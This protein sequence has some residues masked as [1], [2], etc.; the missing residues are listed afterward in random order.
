MPAFDPDLTPTRGMGAIAETFRKQMDV[1]RSSHPQVSFTAWGDDCISIVQNHSLAF[2][3]GE[4]SP[5]A[6]MYDRDGWVLL[7]GVGHDS[8]TSL[9]LAEDRA[10]YRKKE[11]IRCSSP[12]L[13]EGHRRWKQYEDWNYDDSD[14]RELGHDFLKDNQDTVAVGSI[15]YAKCQLFSQRLCVDYAADWFEHKRR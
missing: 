5:L 2:S 9:H 4:S 8:N 13:I 6:R 12:I 14:F 10:E 3:L 7:M 15:G 11:I 1:V